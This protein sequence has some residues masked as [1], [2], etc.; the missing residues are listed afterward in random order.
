MKEFKSYYDIRTFTNR[1]DIANYI[2]D[3]VI[4]NTLRDIVF[5]GYKDELLPILS[6]FSNG[7]YD[8]EFRQIIKDSYSDDEM[9]VIKHIKKKNKLYKP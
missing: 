1:L 2:L 5:K 4:D 7:I 6:N 9:I 8:L 3:S